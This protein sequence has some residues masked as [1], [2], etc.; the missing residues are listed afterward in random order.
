MLVKDWMQ[1]ETN[2]IEANTPLETALSLMTDKK[3]SSLPVTRNGKP[4]GMVSLSKLAQAVI[5]G[6]LHDSTDPG[7]SPLTRPV[8][9]FMGEITIS[10]SPFATIDEAA[11]IL[12]KTGIPALPVIDE[13]G[14]MS[15]VVSEKEIYQVFSSLAGLQNR[16]FDFGF[17]V[18]D[19]PGSIK[20]ITDVIRH[21][22][23]RIASILISYDQVPEDFRNV[24]I[25]VYGVERERLKELK[26]ELCQQ[27]QML[28]M[29]DHIEHSKV[30]F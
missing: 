9:E 4:A 21:H 2:A 5:S 18:A 14:N 6:R 23:G 29:F 16:E 26:N 15:G 27:T 19:S 7:S 8:A 22:G 11:A 28:Y 24:F 10:V 1:R 13:D 3:L 20:T 25:R 30:I 12:L 17:R